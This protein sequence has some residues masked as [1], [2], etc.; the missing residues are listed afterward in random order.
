MFI[1]ILLVL[2]LAISIVCI[3]LCEISYNE[4]RDLPTSKTAE[5]TEWQS[6]ILTD[7]N[8]KLIFTKLYQ[9]DTHTERERE[10][11]T[12]RYFPKTVKSH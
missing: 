6:H 10:R 7:L 8:Q 2:F 11:Q 1:Q 12:D 3:Q 9:G 5:K 4:S